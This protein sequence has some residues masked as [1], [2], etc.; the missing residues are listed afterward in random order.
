MAQLKLNS[1]DTDRKEDKDFSMPARKRDA[2]KNPRNSS[3]PCYSSSK[4]RHF[5]PDCP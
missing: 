1:N 5:A 4:K 3:N 2:I